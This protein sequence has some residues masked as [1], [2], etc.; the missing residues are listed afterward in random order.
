MHPAVTGAKNKYTKREL[1]WNK[2]PPSQH[3]T[4][5]L[6]GKKRELGYD[7]LPLS[8]DWNISLRMLC[9][10]RLADSLEIVYTRQSWLAPR[11][12]LSR[13][14]SDPTP[15]VTLPSE[16]GLQFFM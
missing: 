11:V 14:P 4:A 2:S 7:E 1:W 8:T 15:R 5:R 9:V 3:F 10:T 13:Q 16:P 6:H 12:T